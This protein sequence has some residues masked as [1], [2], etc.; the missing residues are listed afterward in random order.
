[1]ADKY[2]LRASREW[3]R[4][5]SHY[6]DIKDCNLR[7]LFVE[8]PGRA[9]SF[10]AQAAGIYLDY[11]RNRIT[12]L[13]MSLL[14]DLARAAGLETEIQRMFGGEKVNFTEDRPALHVALR[15]R[16]GRPVV[17]DGRDIM[18]EVRV[19]ADRM[20]EL[21]NRIRSGDWKGYTGRRIVNIVNIGIGGS[22]L[23]IAMAYEALK[24]YSDRE[25]TV[26]FI[27][28]IDGADFAE[29]TRDLD[30]AETLFVVCSKSFTTEETMTNAETAKRWLA[31]EL[32]AEESAKFHFVAVSSNTGK[33]AEFG[34]AE[35]NVF[36]MW[37]WVGGRYSLC[38]AVGLSLMIAIGPENFEKMLDGFHMMDKH[39]L[40]SELETNIPVILALLGIWHNNFF[41]CETHAVLPYEQYLARFPAHLQQLDMES[42]GKSVNRLGELVDYQTGPIVWGQPGTNGQHAFYQLMHQGKKLVPADFI[43]FLESCQPLGDHHAKLIAN[44][45]AQAEALAFGKTEEQVQSE[46]VEG[47]LVM[48]RIFEGNRP[49]NVILGQKLTPETLGALVSLYEHKV[50]A[51]GV[52]WRINSFD[53]WGVELGKVLAK[54]T[55]AE[56]KQ[57]SRPLAHDPATNRLINAYR[58]G[59]LPGDRD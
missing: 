55:L 43:G 26:R 1:M 7:D 22:D 54:A 37:D 14:C 11:S 42:N 10:S 30:A 29:K 32:G 35:E 48:H 51:Q 28:N 39:F 23:G 57:R 19:V 5:E 17:V 8:D 50:F 16:E 27:S 59:R 40:N 41:G 58:S 6:Q 18:P 49:S 21:S 38:S 3:E 9:Q 52:I 46:G 15:N 56:I 12:G 31:G 4:L 44:M 47:R 33:A 36:C 20:K 45:I 25:L 13:T 24:A 34:I 53:Q 2:N